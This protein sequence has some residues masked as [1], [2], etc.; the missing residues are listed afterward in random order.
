VRWKTGVCQ[1]EYVAGVL[2]ETNDR[3]NEGIWLVVRGRVRV[4]MA[5]HPERLS[6]PRVEPGQA[7]SAST[8][9]YS[10][11]WSELPALEATCSLAGAT[12]AIVPATADML[13]PVLGSAGYHVTVTLPTDMPSGPFESVVRIETREGDQVARQSVGL[14][15]PFSG[16]V[17]RRLA[18]Y[19]AGVEQGGV[20]DLGIHPPGS[21]YQHRLVLKVRDPD[22]RLPLIRAEF[23]PD[24]LQATIGP[25]GMDGKDH[26]YQLEITIP[27]DAPQCIYRGAPAGEMKLYFAH[28]RIPE[29]SLGLSFAVMRRR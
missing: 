15:V 29:L 20:V 3:S 14:E 25:A 4:Q 27:A 12:C 23:Q 10:Q 2:V 19:G 24:F 18:V 8:L 21:V 16:R 28:P 7:A 6:I 9:V 11:V 1:P 26:L 22:P 5:A 13:A 17:L